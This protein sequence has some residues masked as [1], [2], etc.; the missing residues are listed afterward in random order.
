MTPRPWARPLLLRVASLM[1]GLIVALGGAEI[2]ALRIEGLRSQARPPAPRLSLFDPNPHGTGSFRLK[3]NLRLTAVVE[4]RTIAVHTNSH[5]MRW[6]EVAAQK[7]T[8][9]KRVVVLGDSFAFGCWSATMETSFVGWLDKKLASP[10]VEVLGFGVGGYGFEDELLLL[11]EEVLRFAP[12]EIVVATYNGNDIRDSFLDT[13]RYVVKD[14]AAELAD[15]AL[16]QKVPEPYRTAPYVNPKPRPPRGFAGWLWKSAFVRL[17]LRATDRDP[18][19]LDFEVSQR[20][21]SYSFWSQTP[22]PEVARSATRRATDLLEEMRRTA[23]EH[24]A[25]L[26]VVAIPTAEQVYALRPAGKGFDIT[27]PQAFLATW[28]AEKGVSFLDLLPVLR[29]AA[30]ARGRRPYLRYDVHFNDLGHEIAGEAMAAWLTSSNRL[31]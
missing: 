6:R 30:R 2:A 7:P 16:E 22:Y 23:S 28:A 15:D 12:D 13:T 4:G 18:P 20:F 10:R 25:R 5:G 11:R 1:V 24:G 14:G 3:P 26:S 19:Y 8:G 21:T 27:L 9:V 17:A 31:R 29:E